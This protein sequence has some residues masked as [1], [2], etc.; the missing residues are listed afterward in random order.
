MKFVADEACMK[1]APTGWKLGALELGPALARPQAALKI[2][3]QDVFSHR[4]LVAASS[5]LV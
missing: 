1:L 3:L 5:G 2:L 4:L